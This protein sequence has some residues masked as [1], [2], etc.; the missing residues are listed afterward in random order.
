M[1]I[2][3]LNKTHFISLLSYVGIGL[4]ATGISYGFFSNKASII[5]IIL[6]FCL[7]IIAQLFKKNESTSWFQLL[8]FGIVF[9]IS[10]GMI[11]GGILYFGSRPELALWII[12]TGFL[13][14]WLVFG[15]RYK[16]E[17][18]TWVSALGGIFTTALLSAAVYG[19]IMYLPTPRYVQSDHTNTQS[20]TGTIAT[21]SRLEKVQNIIFW[22]SNGNEARQSGAILWMENL[23]ESEITEHCIA[24][25]TMEGC[26]MFINTVGSGTN[27]GSIITTGT[28]IS[29]NHADMV[30]SEVDFVALMIPHHQEAV[31]ST[32]SLLNVTQNPTLQYLGNN[33]VTSQQEE[34]QMM[35]ERL[36][37]IFAGRTYTGIPYMPMMR[38]IRTISSTQTAEKMWLEDMVA[39]HQGAVDM[40]KKVLT[41]SPRQEIKTFAENIIKVQSDEIKLM[42]QLLSNY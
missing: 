23:T 37:G 21:G 36:S 4:L 14:S 19:L 30:N 7:F 34:I 13:V 24:I 27:S 17:N 39:H 25:P 33:I 11:I 3:G 20:T 28:E 1:T 31:D 9:T 38:E 29:H 22:I 35:Q 12:P 40:A 8:L 42:N 41:L 6:G 32:I 10:I 16:W 5:F 15:I 18:F 26:D 2:M